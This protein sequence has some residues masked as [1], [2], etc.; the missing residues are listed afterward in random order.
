MLQFFSFFP[1]SFWA[2]QVPRSRGRRTLC[3]SQ[4][5]SSDQTRKPKS[6]FKHVFI[7]WM[8]RLVVMRNVPTTASLRRPGALQR[9]GRH[10]VQVAQ[11][12]AGPAQQ[13]PAQML[14]SVVARIH[15]T[16][17]FD[18][19]PSER[20]DSPLEKA[21]GDSISQDRKGLKTHAR[22]EEGRSG[23]ASSRKGSGEGGGEKRGGGVSGYQ[24]RQ[25]DVAK[26][27]DRLRGI[28]GT[29]QCIDIRPWVSWEA[30]GIEMDEIQSVVLLLRRRT[31]RL[32]HLFGEL[33]LDARLAFSVR[34]RRVRQQGRMAH[35]GRAR[36]AHLVRDPLAVAVKFTAEERK[37]GTVSFLQPSSRDTRSTTQAAGTHYF[38]VSALMVPVYLLCRCS[39]CEAAVYRRSDMLAYDLA[40]GM[41]DVVGGWRG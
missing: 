34:Q 13:T 20:H 31:A 1:F 39:S 6:L 40:P 10:Q 33:E 21:A 37:D 7:E 35:D 17:R 4:K 22:R 29:L 32:Q 2:S 19:G 28:G 27:V 18:L 14:V 36:V 5:L 41:D 3:P 30:L 26:V 38:S 9:D 23:R 24:R 12:A 15:R 25:S 16:R 8:G 11:A